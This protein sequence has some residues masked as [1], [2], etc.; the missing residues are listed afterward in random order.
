MTDHPFT[1]HLD[2]DYCG[3]KQCN[4]EIVIAKQKHVVGGRIVFSMRYIWH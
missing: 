3:L 1:I 4:D 2:T